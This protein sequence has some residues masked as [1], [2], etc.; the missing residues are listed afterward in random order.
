[1][2]N[3]MTTVRFAKEEE[4]EQV[5]ALRKQV[6]DL[7]AQGKPSV[8]NP[9]F[10]EEL[11]DYIYSIWNDPQKEIVVNEREGFQLAMPSCITFT[12]PRAHL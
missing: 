2:M 3:K 11:R 8:F 7:H 10:S 1:M 5:N 6:Y 12:C 9:E 4:L